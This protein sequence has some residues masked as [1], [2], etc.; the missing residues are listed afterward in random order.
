M[1]SE[2]GMGD[3]TGDGTGEWNGG[4][5]RANTIMASINQ[6]TRYGL[7]DTDAKVKENRNRFRFNSCT[8][9]FYE[10]QALLIANCQ[11]FDHLLMRADLFIRFTINANRSMLKSSIEN[12]SNRDGLD[13][14]DRIYGKLQHFN[15]IF[16]FGVILWWKQ[17]CAAQSP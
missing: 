9:E 12:W 1:V 17:L 8:T 16:T 3:G 10:L 5:Q 7:M 13:E 6:Y 14:K 4:H 15:G 2:G 11:L